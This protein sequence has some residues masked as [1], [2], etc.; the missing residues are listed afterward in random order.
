MFK[1]VDFFLV[2]ES[3]SFKL[4][5]DFKNSKMD[6]VFDNFKRQN[7]M[8]T[9]RRNSSCGKKQT[10]ES[11][12]VS[13]GSVYSLPLIMLISKFAIANDITNYIHTCYTD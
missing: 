8:K 7:S 1:D 13:K 6:M 9:C 2:S 4:S 5:V 12:P 10:N 11:R 3:S